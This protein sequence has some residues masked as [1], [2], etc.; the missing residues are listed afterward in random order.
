MDYN[1]IKT[2]S[3][4]SP[5]TWGGDVVFAYY[6]G[7][8]SGTSAV[9]PQIYY[10]YGTSSLTGG[11]WSPCAVT[12]QGYRQTVNIPVGTGILQLGSNMDLD[13]SDTFKVY[14]TSTALNSTALDLKIDC[15]LSGVGATGCG[16]GALGLWEINLQS[17]RNGVFNISAPNLTSVGDQFAGSSYIKGQTVGNFSCNINIPNVVGAGNYFL[18]A[19]CSRSSV[20]GCVI[21]A[22]KLVGVGSYGFQYFFGYSTIVNPI[23]IT[24]PALINTDNYFC[25]YFGEYC[26]SPHNINMNLPVLS[27]IRAYSFYYG[28]YYSTLTADYCLTDHIHL[29][30]SG[31]FAGTYIFAQLFYDGNLGNYNLSLGDFSN[32]TFGN[33]SYFMYYSIGLLKTTS[34]VQVVLPKVNN[35]IV[36]I[37]NNFVFRFGYGSPAVMTIVIP[38]GCEDIYLSVNVNNLNF[39]NISMGNV[40][41]AAGGR[42]Q[43]FRGSGEWDYFVDSQI[44]PTTNDTYFDK[45]TLV[46]SG[47]GSIGFSNGATTVLTNFLQRNTQGFFV[48]P[49]SNISGNT[50]DLWF[51]GSPSL[52]G[53]NSNWTSIVWTSFKDRNGT[54]APNYFGY[55]MLP[56]GYTGGFTTPSITFSNVGSGYLYEAY[57]GGP[58]SRPLFLNSGATVSGDYF[59]YRTFVNTPSASVTLYFTVTGPWSYYQTFSGASSL[60]VASILGSVSGAYAYGFTFQ[61]CNH[62]TALTLAANVGSSSFSNTFVGAFLP[63][64][65]LGKLTLLNSNNNTLSPATNSGELQNEKILEID[66]GTVN[67][68]NSFVNATLWSNID[69]FK[70][71]PRASWFQMEGERFDGYQTTNIYLGASGDD[72]LLVMTNGASKIN[73]DLIPW[74]ELDENEITF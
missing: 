8:N 4:V 63:S 54:V 74:T 40:W 5:T 73:N 66:V 56:A 16:T 70:F 45:L 15:D 31:T 35:S 62:L 36:D 3:F 25:N 26:T 39:S 55:R 1:T 13:T 69:D 41:V 44:L 57:L 60:S 52:N 65:V 38:E 20:T 27:S 7:G 46:G 42:Y 68:R 9:F 47:A 71:I 29:A 11:G 61:S 22:P 49:N 50:G 18:G 59:L 58:V 67:N 34:R 33:Y 6:R 53:L 2:F 24:L 30:A 43:D 14:S 37:N 19:I 32:Y 51:N 28:F 12:N 17:I 72:D 10:R 23:T 48:T 21:N 64:S